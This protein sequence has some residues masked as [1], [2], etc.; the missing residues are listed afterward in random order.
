MLSNSNDHMTNTGGR[1]G[2]VVSA[3]GELALA[4]SPSA[5]EEEGLPQ[6]AGDEWIRCIYASGYATGPAYSGYPIY[7]GY[8][9]DFL[10]SLIVYTFDPPTIIDP[11]C[12]DEWITYSTKPCKKDV[13]C[14]DSN[15]PPAE[16]LANV[17]PTELSVSL[18][19]RD[20]PKKSN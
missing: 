11:N 5:S 1:S 17:R 14:Y 20:L 12:E 3:D 6:H 10:E 8:N 7:V 13:L 16:R 15:P 18:I 4:L 9:P 2:F 19:C